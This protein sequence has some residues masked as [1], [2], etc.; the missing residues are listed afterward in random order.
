MAL[1]PHNLRTLEARGLD[2]EI[3]VRYGV[4]DSPRLGTSC[5]V[6]PFRE[7]GQVVNRK[8][9]T[10][11]GDKKF[12]QDAGA[13][14][15]FWNV[16]VIAD[17]SLAELPLIITEGELDA[18]SAIQAGYLR[19]VSVPDGAPA[20]EVGEKDSA[21]YT[22]LDNV[23]TA[24]ADVREIIL[25]TDSDD[26]G[27]NLMHDLALRLG[28]SR[29]KWLKYPKGC[30]DLNDALRLFGVRGVTETIARAQW[31][32]VPGVYRMGEMPP[33]P[34]RSAYDMGLP[35]V[36]EHYKLRLG[37]MA[38]MTG[39][40]GHGKSTFINE[41]GCRMALNFNWPVAFASF[42]QTPQTDHRRALRSW[43]NQK[44]VIHQSP[45]EIA[46][47]DA[48]IEQM[49]TFI[50][51]GD[52]DD[53]T[54]EWTL[55]RM[56]VAVLRNGCKLVV[57]D[58]WN[59]MDHVR[60]PDMSLT[61]YT[62][63]AIKQFRKFARKHRIHL[64]IAAHPVKQRKLDSGDFAIPTL[65]DISDS[66]HWY[67]KSDVGMVVHRTSAETILRVA[68]TRYHDQIGTPGDVKMAFD[69]QIWRYRVMD[70]K[71]AELLD[72]PR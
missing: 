51:P 25:A 14:K 21:K 55:E 12:I 39:I 66:Q 11:D 7:R 64:I 65:Y 16:D 4:D 71:T 34:E 10:I 22:F 63:F 52:D 47:A 5:V 1:S 54:L 33:L 29:C 38:V 45:H 42:E 32:A 20:Q 9:R 24:L 56:S 2:P 28:R 62:G 40:P 3:L 17:K 57:V 49:F 41:I 13:R 44:R 27:T 36:G 8:Y 59:E 53:V 61:E 30:K 19:T 70:Q 35:E 15:V 46:S 68:K 50:V 69:K 23:P 26:P 48:W 18:L 72:D 31:I 6:I 58:P 60:P 67:N 43:F 37:D